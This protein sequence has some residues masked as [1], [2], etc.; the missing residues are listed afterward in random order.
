MFNLHLYSLELKKYGRKAGAAACPRR[1]GGC[2]RSPGE[3]CGVKFG[4]ACD[5]GLV[6]H[7]Q[8]PSP[9]APGRSASIIVEGASDLI[10]SKTS[11][12]NADGFARCN[13]PANPLTIGLPGRKEEI[14]AV[15]SKVRRVEV[16]EITC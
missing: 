11:T 4:K 5:A 14:L 8:F 1:D 2:A 9:P 12:Q 13:L 6:C 15:S 16:V 7:Q 3:P 10:D